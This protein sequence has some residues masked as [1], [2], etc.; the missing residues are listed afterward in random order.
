M[1]PHALAL[2]LVR[3]CR[4]TRGWTAFFTALRGSRFAVA[5]ALPFSRLRYS[6]VITLFYATARALQTFARFLLTC[7]RTV[8][9]AIFYAPA[10]YTSHRL[11]LVAGFSLR[12]SIPFCYTRCHSFSC[13]ITVA[14]HARFVHILHLPSTPPVPRYAARHS[15]HLFLRLV[16]AARIALTGSWLRISHG[17]ARPRSVSYASRYGYTPLHLPPPPVAATWILP[18]RYAVIFVACLLR[19]LVRHWTSTLT[20]VHTLVSLRLTAVIS[21]L[22]RCPFGTTLRLTFC[23]TLPP[24]HVVP[25]VVVTTAVTRTG[26]NNTVWFCVFLV[27]RGS[28]AYRFIVYFAFGCR[29]R[30]C[31]HDGCYACISYTHARI[32]RCTRL[33][34]NTTHPRTRGLR[35]LFPGRARS[36]VYGLQ[37]CV[38]AWM[39]VRHTAVHMRVC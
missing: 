28:N 18:V 36:V 39:L 27:Y 25:G 3:L 21:G 12:L 2:Q 20:P 35:W 6:F 24:T 29:S 16:A 14:F 1:L 11:Y 23:D 5:Y 37:Y 19:I 32:L 10:F 38:A 9:R 33:N 26:S 17:S 30:T 15:Q 22:C 7:I 8:T 13:R 34:Q 31:Q 4:G